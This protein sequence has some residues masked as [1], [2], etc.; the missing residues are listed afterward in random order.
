MDFLDLE[1]EASARDQTWVSYKSDLFFELLSHLSSPQINLKQIFLNVTKVL[2]NLGLLS[3]HFLKLNCKTFS[4]TSL[5]TSLQ[6]YFWYIYDAEDIKI[7][8]Q[9]I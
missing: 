3:Y 8:K 2:R 6:L 9:L 1:L 7:P 5:L 4:T